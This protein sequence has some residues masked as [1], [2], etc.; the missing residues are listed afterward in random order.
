[1]F[2]AGSNL[3]S[4]FLALHEELQMIKAL[5]RLPVL[6][7]KAPKQKRPAL[8]QTFESIF[9]PLPKLRRMKVESAGRLS[10]QLIKFFK[11]IV[12]VKQLIDKPF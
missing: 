12:S 10:N 9:P 2:L 11:C 1:M 7:F 4:D 5:K 6:H 8:L 3:I